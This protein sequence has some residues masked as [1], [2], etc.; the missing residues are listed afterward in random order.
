MT[1]GCRT[2]VVGCALALV[3]WMGAPAAA[4]TVVADR[5]RLNTGPIYI[6]SGSNSPEG[7]VTASPGAIYARCD[8]G[9][10]CTNPALYQ[11]LSGTGNTGWVKIADPATPGVTGSGTATYLAGWTGTY[12]LGASGIAYSGA[13]ITAGVWQASLIG[14]A[15]GGTAKNLTAA[16]GGVLWTDADSAEVTAAGNSGDWLK[17]TGAT[18]PAWTA[19]GA[20]T[21]SDDTNVTLTLGGSH[22]TALLNAASLTLGWTGQLSLARGGT[23]K[24]MTAVAGG[25][26]YTDADSMEVGAA[27]SSGQ[28][29]RS[30]GSGTPVWSTPTWPNA[31]A[32]A[33]YLRGDGTNWIESTL[34]LPNAATQYRVVFAS[35]TDTYGEDADL[36]FTTD[37]LYATKVASSTLT[38]TRVT[39]AGASG[40]L[41]DD[42]DLTFA[43]DT[44]SATKVAS[45]SLTS[46]RVPYAT[47]AGLLV[48]DADLTFA[49]DTLTA[50]KGVT[51]TSLT[52]PLVYAYGAAKSLTMG[53]TGVAGCSIADPAVGGTANCEAASYTFT[54]AFLE[55]RLT[56]NSAVRSQWYVQDAQ[57]TVPAFANLTAYNNS[58][59]TG[60]RLFGAPVTVGG[61]G[62]HVGIAPTLDPGEGNAYV[63]G[64]I[65]GVDPVYV[66]QTTGMSLDFT[67]GSIDARY[68]VVDEMHAKKFIADLEQAL[69]GG[70]IISKSVGMIGAAFTVPDKGNIS[71]LTMRDLPSA[72]D[73]AIFESGDYVR[74]RTFLRAA[75]SLT[76]TD[77]WGI[78]SGYSDQADGLQ[79]WNFQR[80]LGDDGGTMAA[81]TVIPVDSLVLDYGVSGNGFHEVN[82]IDGAYG[83]NS[84]YSQIVTWSGASPRS[85]NQTVRTRM[86]N[87]KGITGTTEY[88]L[89]A[90]T[91][92][93]TSSGQYIIFSDT[94]AEIHNVPLS[95]Y[96]G[97]NQTLYLSPTTASLAQA[98][99][100]ASTLT[101]T[102]GTGC[103]SG[104]HGGTFK[105]RCGSDGSDNY[106]AWD[107]TNLTVKGSITVTG[108]LPDADNALALGGVAAATYLAYDAL[109]DVGLT[110]DG[111]P[112][113][114]AVATPSGSG[115]FLGS[116]YM[117]YY[118]SSAWQTYIKSDGTWYFNGDG[119][120]FISWNG[121]TLDIRGKVTLSASSSG[122]SNISDKPTTLDEIEAAA[123]SK[124]DGI[125]AG[126]DVTSTHT[127]AN[128]AA[129]GSTSLVNAED[130]VARARGGLDVNGNITRVITGTNIAAGSA[131]DGLNMTASYLGF[132][133]ATTYPAAPWRTYMDSSGNFYLKGPAATALSWVGGVLTIAGTLSGDGAGVTNITGGN[134]QTGT[135]TATQLSANSVDTDELVAGAVTAAKIDVVDLAAI[136]AALGAITSGS[137]VVV[138]GANTIGLVPAGANAIYAGPT[139]SPTFTVT[140]AGAMTATNATIADWTVAATYIHTASGSG[141]GL[142]STDYPF[143]AGAVYASRASAPFRVTNAGALV[144]TSATITGTVTAAAGAIGG[145]TLAA[146]QLSSGTD[147]DFVA[148]NSGG[149]NALWIGDS[150]FAD[151]K[152]SV[153]SAGVVKA[154]SG[155]IGGFTLASAQLSSGTDADYVAMSSGGT[156]AFWA[157]DS[158]FAD[159]EFSVTAAGA[160][161][162]T[163]ATITGASGTVTIDSNGI[164]LTAG[165][166]WP[167]SSSSNMIRF[168]N[169]GTRFADLSASYV[170]AG[171]NYTNNVGLQL[172]GSGTEGYYWLEYSSTTSSATATIRASGATGHIVLSATKTTSNGNILTNSAGANTLG[173]DGTPFGA[174]YI[175]YLKVGA[176]TGASAVAG[177]VDASVG[178][179]V[180]GVEITAPLY[181]RIAALETR[182][183]QLEA[184]LAAAL[185]GRR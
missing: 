8:T 142:S 137:I 90:G 15:Y 38:A 4:Q 65:R 45:S 152:F 157:G 183:A 86:G 34:K 121:A 69:A 110:A 73:M 164:Y 80:I 50:T 129:L 119:S 12:T 148:L 18:A 111:N 20:L 7:V 182:L 101:Y 59:W 49:T 5:I 168:L 9:S 135:V 37:T 74:I 82:A 100:N 163:N 29:L 103:W 143:F 141:A 62:L 102:S 31:A 130:G 94:R 36:Y 174:G 10:P 39:F 93:S 149:T 120:N 32:S 79:T 127:A 125:E 42:A 172:G 13:N 35:A 3:A 184:A 162:A 175:N 57:D 98:T 154:I 51:P 147:A 16:A 46:G 161:K 181:D 134:I 139:G 33:S 153:T 40:L 68:I 107:G 155:T 112:A 70:Q 136:N 180:N 64:W 27:G 95:L 178:F 22:T 26:V 92:G 176:P 138:N 104:I 150:T 67:D 47:T 83:V 169:G 76:I 151:A 118:A 126:A 24:N 72:E 71:V 106:I 53:G 117:G 75:G 99:A 58:G 108:T 21:K 14:L 41:V 17:S 85:A 114:P 144:A 179:Y 43:T 78:V 88:G 115:L 113:L 6:Y 109:V 23:A 173:A 54:S 158:T 132:Y 167:P 19:P 105:W 52:T 63:D 116:D 87:L 133:D 177:R 89:L 66:S 61:G 156:N 30:A 55:Q 1:T 124:L 146:N 122:Y 185:E 170:T 171:P 91:Y 11:K 123:A 25:I 96:N 131:V 44:L 140:P 145:F 48:D 128:T 159:A 2:F 165:T 77:A 166:A 160:L 97:S 28:M 56:T 60:L 84:P 81:A